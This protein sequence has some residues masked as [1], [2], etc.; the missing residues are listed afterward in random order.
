MDVTVIDFKK[1]NQIP[2]RFVDSGRRRTHQHIRYAGIIR[3]TLQKNAAKTQRMGIVSGDDSPPFSPFANIVPPLD[4]CR[5]QSFVV[6]IVG[7]VTG[8]WKTGKHAYQAKTTQ[9]AH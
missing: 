9:R 4:T 5:F 3:Y 8:E 6:S 2:R 7:G 1:Y